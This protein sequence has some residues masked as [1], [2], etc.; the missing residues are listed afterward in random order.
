[1]ATKHGLVT[2]PNDKA[3]IAFY[4]DHGYLNDQSVGKNIYH[5]F[6]DVK[7]RLVQFAGKKQV[8]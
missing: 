2:A 1:M 7:T 6:E 5:Q 3:N 4:D 8:R